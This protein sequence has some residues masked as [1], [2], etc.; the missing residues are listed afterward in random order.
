MNKSLWTIDA[1]AQRPSRF[2]ASNSVNASMSISSIVG[3]FVYPSRVAR[4]RLGQEMYFLFVS[5]EYGSSAWPEAYSTG[6]SL[7]DA[8]DRKKNPDLD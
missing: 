8:A 5:K 3:V 2:R 6:S 7:C 1:T 4:R